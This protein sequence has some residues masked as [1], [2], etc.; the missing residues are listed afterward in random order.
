MNPAAPLVM[1]IVDDLPQE[2]SCPQQNVSWEIH[3]P[4]PRL[5]QHHIVRRLA[6]A[7]DDR[8]DV[9]CKVLA[10]GAEQADPQRLAILGPA[11]AA[12]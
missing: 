8:K 2:V 11:G 7:R 3:D 9:V 10:L 5:S 4:L 12:G 1:E 6:T